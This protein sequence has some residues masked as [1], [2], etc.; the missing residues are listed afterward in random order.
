MDSEKEKFGEEN[1]VAMTLYE[2]K[3][4]CIN[5]QAQATWDD[6]IQIGF[7]GVVNLWLQLKVPKTA[8]SSS[9][10]NCFVIMLKIDSCSQVENCMC[11]DAQPLVVLSKAT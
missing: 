11:H 3:Q 6:G 1:K 7:R 8:A 10:D 9:I 4:L 2:F 5:D